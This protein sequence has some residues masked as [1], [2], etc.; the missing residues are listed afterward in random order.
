[1]QSKEYKNAFYFKIIVLYF[2]ATRFI[3]Y[4]ETIFRKSRIFSTKSL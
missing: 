4:L 3:Y 2:G 1:M